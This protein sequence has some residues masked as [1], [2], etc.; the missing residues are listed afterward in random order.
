MAGL[1]L[2]EGEGAIGLARELE[3][4]LAVAE[5]AGRALDE[6]EPLV[7][8]G[9]IARRDQAGGERFA[10]ETVGRVVLGVVIGLDSGQQGAFSR[11]GA[12]VETGRAAAPPACNRPS[13]RRPMLSR[14]GDATLNEPNL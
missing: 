12:D 8:L 11:P 14:A 3:L 9:A 7:C 6:R 5:A 2:V 13:A 4:R 10:E 1:G